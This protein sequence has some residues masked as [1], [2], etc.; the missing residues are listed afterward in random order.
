MRA[1]VVAHAVKGG[2]CVLDMGSGPGT[3]SRP[4]S[5]AGGEPVLLDVSGAMLRTAP[6]PNRV[7]GTFENLPFRDGAFDSVVSGF[8]VRDALDLPTALVQVR[9]VLKRGGRFAF[10]DIGKPSSRLKAL[11]VGV[12]MRVVPGVV[13]L[14]TAGRA[15]LKYVSL[16]DTYLLLLNNSELA[17]A[18][19]EL[20]RV[21][22]VHETQM[23][24]SV[25]VTCKD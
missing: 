22:S 10:C 17:H 3:L 8:A 2:W 15:G 11:L 9:R 20:F 6:F 14:V 12:Y 7:R 25:V 5:Q 21:V 13:G 1:E 18:L 16:Y 24:G 23:G 19:R 4:V